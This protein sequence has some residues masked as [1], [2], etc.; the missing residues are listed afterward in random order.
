MI[1]ARP[2]ALSEVP[3]DV[4]TWLVLG[5]IVWLAIRVLTARLFGAFVG[6]ADDQELTTGSRA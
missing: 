3:R 2:P 6:D 5:L 1:P 4:L